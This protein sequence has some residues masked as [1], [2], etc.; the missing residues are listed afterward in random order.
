MATWTAK[1]WLGSDN[2]YQQLEVQSNTPHGAKQQLKKIYGAESVINLRQVSSNSN[3]KKSESSGGLG[4]IV[5]S[6]IVLGA[7]SLF[8][9]NNNNAPATSAP[10]SQ[11]TTYAKVTPD[12]CTIWANANPTL[13]AKLQPGDACYS[14]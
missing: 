1:C 9:S 6:V 14:H 13:A 12:P 5:L 8:N 10:I 7:L 4:I 11:S 3:S 2:G